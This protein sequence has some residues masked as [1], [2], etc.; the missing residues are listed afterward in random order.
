MVGQTGRYKHHL[1]ISQRMAA[2]MT[3][4]KQKCASA[5]ALGKEEVLTREALVVHT[6]RVEMKQ[7]KEV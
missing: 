5:R 3:R 4:I 1:S 6:D 7:G 2:G